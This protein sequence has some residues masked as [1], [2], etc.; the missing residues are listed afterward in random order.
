MV[1]SNSKIL[2]PLDLLTKLLIFHTLA[3]FPIEFHNKSN[4]ILYNIKKST[5]IK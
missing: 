2:T 4:N 5:G 1:F 3:P